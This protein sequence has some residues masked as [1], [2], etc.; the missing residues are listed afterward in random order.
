MAIYVPKRYTGYNIV[1]IAQ[2]KNR[3]DA[4]DD[5]DEDNKEAGKIVELDPTKSVHPHRPPSGRFDSYT[6]DT[7]YHIL[8]DIP[9]ITQK[10]E[11]KDGEVEHKTFYTKVAGK[12]QLRWVST[13]GRTWNRLYFF[14]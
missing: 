12:I 4:I 8:V 5:P 6:A 9:P 7:S 11:S 14:R 13:D 2:L 1:T 3:P 10:I